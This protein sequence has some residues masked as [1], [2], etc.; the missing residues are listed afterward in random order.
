[1]VGLGRVEL[2]TSSLGNCCSIHLSYSPT[3]ID[4][5]VLAEFERLHGLCAH[6]LCSKVPKRYQTLQ[7]LSGGFVI[8]WPCL[9]ENARENSGIF[10]TTPLMRY[11]AGE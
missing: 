5:Y 1:M 6:K 9:H 3:L 8:G 7:I 11:L 10:T 2:P 4:Y